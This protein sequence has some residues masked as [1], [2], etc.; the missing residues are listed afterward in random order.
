MPLASRSKFQW[1]RK[2]DDEMEDV[3]VH[4]VWVITKGSEHPAEPKRPFARLGKKMTIGTSS[5]LRK[6]PTQTIQERGKAMS[7]QT[8]PRRNI[9]LSDEEDNNLVFTS[10]KD[11]V[12]VKIKKFVDQR[13]KNHIS[14]M[15]TIASLV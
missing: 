3:E 7:F 9:D 14:M 1:R 6:D 5:M 12:L 15:H 13:E 11:L 2:E 8:S 4:N 10:N